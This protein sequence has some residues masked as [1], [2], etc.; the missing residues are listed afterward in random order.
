[1]ATWEELSVEARAAAKRLYTARCWRASVNRSYYAA[2]SACTA[3]LAATVGSFGIDEKGR[4]KESPSHRKLPAMLERNLGAA[5]WRAVRDLLSRLRTW[6]EDAD[7]HV[8]VELGQQRA[9]AALHDA[10]AIMRKLIR[11]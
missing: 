9:S 7:Y 2:F 1:M 11:R 3:F 8:S 10:A 6:R 4:P 5:D